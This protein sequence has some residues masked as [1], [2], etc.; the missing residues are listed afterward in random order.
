[1][2]CSV[3]DIVHTPDHPKHSFGLWT[4]YI[5]AI[6]CIVGAGFLGIPWAYGN[7]GWLFC[8][9]Y[10]IF[11][12]IQSYFL[13]LQTLESMSRADVLIQRKER[14]EAIP[15]LSF[16][17]LFTR[18][19]FDTLLES[20]NS[21]TIS[22]RLVNCPDICKLAFGEKAGSVYLVFLFLYMMGTMVAYAAIFSSSFASNVPLGTLSTCDIYSHS[23]FFNDCRWK[24]WIYLLIFSVFSVYMTVRGIHEQQIIQFIMSGLRF[25][26]LFLILITCIIN[27]AAH[28][29]NDDDGYN[30]ADMP[31]V[32]RPMNIGHAIPIILFASAYQVHIPTISDSIGNKERNLKTIN[33]MAVMTC[34]IFYTLLG[35]LASI[36][37]E[38]VPSMASLGY[39]NYTAGTSQ[40]DRQGWTYLI[41]YLIIISPA[42]DVMTAYPI[43]ALTISD[44]LITWRYGGELSKIDKKIIYSVRFVISSF[45]LL[46][47]F[48][49]Y[50]LGT[51]L[52]WVGLLGFLIIHI[53]IPLFHIAMKH[54]VPGKSVY[55]IYG[56]VWLNWSFSFINTILFFTVIGFNLSEY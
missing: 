14:G 35:M 31:P 37:I 47:S 56:S 15:K 39:R 24:Y 33:L 28:K 55:D 50:N 38:G 23:G 40:S 6:N 13:A 5:F 25:V 34:F 41:E 11:I 46:I 22:D 29:E 32:I 10:Q 3:N 49:V 8:L 9:V 1:M 42:L 27:I 51:I 17:Q 26:V 16:K 7:A 2:D 19:H 54:L 52:D 21:P 20:E 44:S 45:P 53:P 48:L 30:S 12:S 4:G 43:K 36:A 18:P